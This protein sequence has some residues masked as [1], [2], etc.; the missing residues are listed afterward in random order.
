VTRYLF[1][2]LVLLAATA[3]PVVSAAGSA[4]VVMT[5]SGGD[6]PHPVRLA[7]ADEDAFSRRINTPP[8]LDNRP[9]RAT[10]ATYTLTSPYWSDILLRPGRPPV[11]EAATYF[12][13]GG[14]VRARQAGQDIWL[15]L[16]LRQQAILARYLRLTKAGA[17][18]ERPSLVSVLVA[19]VREENVTVEAAGSPLTAGQVGALWSALASTRT[20]QFL[21][22]PQPPKAEGGVWLVFGLEEGR[23]LQLFYEPR[24]ASLTDALGTERYSVTP[25][26]AAVLGSIKP[27][28]HSIDDAVNP[29]SSA[30]WVVM[31]AGGILGL[32]AAYWFLR[33]P[34]RLPFEPKG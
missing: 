27:T 31:I 26:L 28:P 3:W 12:A 14:I 7:P 17:L 4:V 6:L 29:G 32:A 21:D 11:E 1:A 13:E 5:I 30:W 25:A 16:D 34:L 8:R 22:T 10:G 15:A 20:P 24:S 18:D 33:H 2:I 9:E 23:S 19:S